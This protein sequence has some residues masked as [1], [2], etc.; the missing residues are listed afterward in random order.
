MT[1]VRDAVIFASL[2]NGGEAGFDPES[3]RMIGWLDD[4]YDPTEMGPMTR[5]KSERP[6]YDGQFPEHPLSRARWV[7]NHLEHTLAIDEA[8]KRLPGFVWRR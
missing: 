1:G 2:M 6:E 5:N 4:P 8:I 7:L 3:E